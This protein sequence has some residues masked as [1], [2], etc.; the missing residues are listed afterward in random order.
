MTPTLANRVVWLIRC[1]YY[2]DATISTLWITN[3]TSASEIALAIT[4]N[5]EFSVE[6]AREINLQ[7]LESGNVRDKYAVV[8][9]IPA[10]NANTLYRWTVRTRQRY[11][12]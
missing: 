8:R 10:I 4:C 5:D 6:G 9:L 11:Q 2:G 1:V 12:I 3:D 7:R